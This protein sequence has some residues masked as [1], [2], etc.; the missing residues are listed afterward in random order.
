MSLTPQQ[1]S[2]RARLAAYSLHAQT[3][4]KEHMRPAREAF[5]RRF[6]TQV[7]PDGLLSPAERDR[8]AQHALKAYMTTLALKSAKSRAVNAAEKR[9]A[10]TARPKS[11][12]LPE[13]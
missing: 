4:S 3:D 11:R 7:D 10:G 2:I 12:D 6:E 8:R 5:M 1:R 13:L 9:S